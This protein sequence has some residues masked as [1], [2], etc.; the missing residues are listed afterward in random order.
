MSHT[1]DAPELKA[2]PDLVSKIIEL[3]DP[4]K[5]VEI[6]INELMSS[7]VDFVFRVRK[8]RI[9]EFQLSRAVSSIPA[10]LPGVFPKGFV[11]IKTLKDLTTM[12][13]I[14]VHAD[15]V[16]TQTDA[17]KIKARG[18][19]ELSVYTNGKKV[20]VQARN[21]WHIEEV[22]EIEP[23]ED[24]ENEKKRIEKLENF[25]KEVLITFIATL[26]AELA[27]KALM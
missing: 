24:E 3:F 5:V 17:S 19:G 16:I 2:V 25:I 8:V 20:I 11:P 4:E 1:E 10:Y 22:M 7:I 14:I 27:T 26:L 12:T 6:D 13:P 23:R 18:L 9:E 21:L 15:F